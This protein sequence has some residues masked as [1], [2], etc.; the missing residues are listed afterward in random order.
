MGIAPQR[1]CALKTNQAPNHKQTKP[2]AT[3]NPKDAK[4]KFQ[5]TRNQQRKHSSR[6]DRSL[7]V[8][9]QYRKP[10]VHLKIV[11]AEKRTSKN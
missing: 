11:N 10:I 7:D 9:T 6:N 5:E 4:L 2:A 1:T 8:Q 3:E